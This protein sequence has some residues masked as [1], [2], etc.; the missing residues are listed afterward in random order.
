MASLEHIDCL[1]RH[2]SMMQQP[3]CTA[4]ENSDDPFGLD[5]GIALAGLGWRVASQAM[6]SRRRVLV[7]EMCRVQI[8]VLNLW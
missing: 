7:L 2:L 5:E 8:D 1:R 6:E 4:I 3:V